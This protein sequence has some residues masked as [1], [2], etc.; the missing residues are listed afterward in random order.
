MMSKEL[1]IK[2]FLL[3]FSL[4]FFTPALFAQSQE[5]RVA[6]VALTVVSGKTPILTAGAL[7]KVSGGARRHVADIADD[8]KTDN[9]V[10]CEQG[11]RFEAKAESYFDRPIAPVRIACGPILNFTFTRAIL[12]S[13]P[14]GL[15]SPLTDVAVAPAVYS[16]YA[17]IFQKAGQATAA[18]TLNEA[19]IASAAKLL[20]DTRLDTLVGRDPLQNYLLV[21]NNDGVAALKAIQQSGKIK[22]TGQLDAATQSLLAGQA[23]GNALTPPSVAAMACSFGVTTQVH[24]MPV[25]AKRDERKARMVMLPAM[26]FYQ[27][28]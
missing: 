1:L 9:E 14:E 27:K 22:Q 11:D 24:C 5:I 18:R 17:A 8:G 10:K 4:G 2:Q 12:T 15:A 28:E 19:A 23:K 3:C 26:T 6:Q 20:G 13:S 16:N 21:F 7:Y 25:D